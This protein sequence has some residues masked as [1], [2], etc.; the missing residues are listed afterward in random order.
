MDATALRDT[1]RQ[2]ATDFEWLEAH[3]RAR[4]D[5]A[6]HAGELRL[7]AALT[8]NV[9]GP[10]VDGVKPPPLFVAV[11]GGAGAGKSTVVNFLLGEVAAETNPQAGYTRHPTAFVPADKPWPAHFAFIGPLRRLE[12]ESPANLDEDVY[13]VRK[14]RTSAAMEPLSDFIVWDCPDMTTWAATGYVSR[15][16][17]VAGLADAIIYVASDERYNDEVPTQFLQSLLRAGKAVVVVLTKMN[18]SNAAAMTEHFRTEVLGK[19]S[20]GD[21]RTVP[22]ITLP[23]LSTAQRNDPAGA[24]AAFRVPLLNQLLVLCPTALPTRQR[25]V[26]NAVKFLD[27]ASESLIDVARKDLAELDAWKGAVVAGQAAFQNRYHNEYLAGEP[28]RRFVRSRDEVL[29]LLELPGPGRYVSAA[30]QVLRK[31]YQWL[32]DYVVELA[33]RPAPPNLPE[34]TVLNS[35]MTAWLDS[36]QAESLRRAGNHPLWKQ[37]S[38]GFDAGLK[39]EAQAKF[40]DAARQF[41]VQEAG[42]LE[43]AARSLNDY[44]ANNATTLTILRGVKVAAEV[45]AAVTV[46]AVTWVPSWYQL[47]LVPL[48]VA[49]V[50]QC[51]EWG[52]G[53]VMNAKK[54][55]AKSKREALL[56]DIV[57][58]PLTTWF[59][60]RP[61]S[62]GTPVERLQEILRRVPQ[63]IQ[64]LKATLT[65]AV[66]A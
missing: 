23:Q 61:L 27:A 52:I 10:S 46:I 65:P 39:T 31:P 1:V 12:T 18:E 44:F 19:L 42:D 3:C 16:I 47:L 41:E 32:R 51:F 17:E 29:N 57:T 30:M 63:S 50:H 56:A 43:L 62:G 45:V 20:I 54:N 66:T 48:A 11:V 8:R 5:L 34:R 59:E 25:T 58:K 40:D 6:R 55:A 14:L 22:I 4:P 26:T 53:A 7:A 64:K 2:T 13:Q 21:G 49:T 24:G 15:L 28:F 36:L 37:V 33:A 38:Q 60:Q 35:A 9:I